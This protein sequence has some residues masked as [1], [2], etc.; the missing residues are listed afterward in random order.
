MLPE[1]PEEIYKRRHYGTPESM[2]LIIANYVVMAV[3]IEIWAMGC[4]IN[5]FF[6]V[7]TGLLALYNYYIIRKNREEFDRKTIIAYLCSIAGLLLMFFL[8][9]IKAEACKV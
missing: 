7:A 5:W 4:K 6:W 8:F 9:R 3:S 1:L 2:S